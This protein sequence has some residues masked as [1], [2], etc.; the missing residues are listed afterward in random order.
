MQELERFNCLIIAEKKI[1]FYTFLSSYLELYPSDERQLWFTN[2]D[3]ESLLRMFPG[4]TL[5]PV[6]EYHR[7]NFI[8]NYQS[9]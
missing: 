8:A 4:I 5:Y 2:M 6:S 7:I 9:N 3:Q 1:G